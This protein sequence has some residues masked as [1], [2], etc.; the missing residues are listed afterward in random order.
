VYLLVL[1][2]LDLLYYFPLMP[3][4]LWIRYTVAIWQFVRLRAEVS[5]K[6][7]SAPQFICDHW[8]E[9][10]SIGVFGNLLK[11]GVERRHQL[12]AGVRS[13]HRAHEDA[14]QVGGSYE[15]E[16]NLP[17]DSDHHDSWDAAG[18]MV[19]VGIA[20]CGGVRLDR[21]RRGRMTLP[22]QYMVMACRC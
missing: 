16:G 22:W 9:A 14:G 7:L 4:K 8:K 1:G 10:F 21:R 6:S 11:T 18:G 20:E 13:R 19:Q 3:L 5:D 12:P 2:F 15:A 17:Y